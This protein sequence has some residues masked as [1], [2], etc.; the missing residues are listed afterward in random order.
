MTPEEKAK[1][2]S[3]KMREKLR[4]CRNVW[5]REYPT[6]VDQT[7]YKLV[8]EQLNQLVILVRLAEEAEEMV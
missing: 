1:I 7:L 8:T 4:E 6:E 3:S 2:A 5:S